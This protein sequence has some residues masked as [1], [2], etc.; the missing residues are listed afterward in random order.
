MAKS[1][2]RIVTAADFVKA[3]LVSIWHGPTWSKPGG[4]ANAVTLI[5]C[6]CTAALTLPGQA[7]QAS[8]PQKTSAL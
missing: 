1:A 6:W 5:L 7:C 8:R 3:P 2:S 4:A